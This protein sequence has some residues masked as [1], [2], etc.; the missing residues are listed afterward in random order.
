MRLL[1]DEQSKFCC[2]LPEWQVLQPLNCLC[3]PSLGTCYYAHVSLVLGSPV[4]GAEIQ[5]CHTNAQEKG[6]IIS[7]DML[8]ILYLTQP[9]RLLAFAATAH[10]R[11]VSLVPTGP[12]GLSLR[13]YFSAGCSSTCSDTWGYS[14]Q[15]AGPV[16]FLFWNS[17]DS[18]C[19]LFPAC[20]DPSEWQHSHQHCVMDMALPV[21][22]Q[23]R[24]PG[25]NTA[26][27]L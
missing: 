13:S 24:T 19:A 21:W 6:K 7:F 27:L 9:R 26:D 15:G 10:C 20:W 3:G 18:C 4:Q 25:Y 17:W 14:L 5:M 16:T 1:Q 12:L 11:L 22:D 8:A 23:V 2:L